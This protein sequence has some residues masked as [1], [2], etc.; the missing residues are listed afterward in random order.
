MN[1]IDQMARI[2]REIERSAS[3]VG[4]GSP[5]R[6]A[7]TPQGPQGAG[8]MEAA[9]EKDGWVVSV[10]MMPPESTTLF[11][12]KFGEVPLRSS[13]EDAALK[14]AQAFAKAEFGTD[15]TVERLNEK[16]PN[17]RAPYHV[18]FLIKVDASKRVAELAA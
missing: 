10:A 14:S 18:T 2:E 12:E 4:V 17:T 16:I 8:R 7:R 13:D 5:E 3:A 15:V 9:C 11:I 1:D 6:V